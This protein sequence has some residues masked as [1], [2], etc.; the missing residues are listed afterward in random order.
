MCTTNVTAHVP[1][2]GP[3][4]RFI[5]FDVCSHGADSFA[6]SAMIS[7]TVLR[8]HPLETKHLKGAAGGDGTS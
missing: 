4:F 1:S 7:W 8:V 2:S 5:V 3:S 6:I